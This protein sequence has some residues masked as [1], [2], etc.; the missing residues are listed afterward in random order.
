MEAAATW[1]RRV[2]QRQWQRC[3]RR[4]PPS[5][6]PILRGWVVWRLRLYAGSPGSRWHHVK[7]A[8]R[9]HCCGSVTVREAAER[10]DIG[11]S[12]AQRATARDQGRHRLAQLAPVGRQTCSAA[13]LHLRHCGICEITNTLCRVQYVLRRCHPEPS[14]TAAER[15]CQL[16]ACNHRHLGDE[17]AAQPEQRRQRGQRTRL[18][19][20]A[21]R[22]RPPL[23]AGSVCRR[24]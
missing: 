8:V 5:R 9:A 15:R 23:P 24:Q 22:R 19:A 12:N 10:S 4:E 11:V 13:G 16:A 18:A 1:R 20:G 14:Y 6:S 21:K 7:E 17:R 2:R 3:K